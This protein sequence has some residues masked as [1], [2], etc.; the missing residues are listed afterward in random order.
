MAYKVKYGDTIFDVLLNVCGDY[1]QIDEIL[2]LNGLLSYTPQLTVGQELDV[3]EL[4]TSNNATLIRASKFPYNS[5][6]LS[7]EEFER[8]LE[9]ILDSI[10]GGYYLEVQP[11]FTTVSQNGDNQYVNIYTN[12]TF[13]VL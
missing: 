4:Q 8:Q 5:N 10:K 11:S 6:L 3:E 13:N 12:S 2:S 1:S 9:Q 7:D